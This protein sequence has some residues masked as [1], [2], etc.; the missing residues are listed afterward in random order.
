MI[1]SHQDPELRAEVNQFRVASIACHAE[2]N[3]PRGKEFFVRK[4][5]K[6][7]LNLAQKK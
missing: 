3:P 6:R 7:D 2:P 4:K 5:W 1:S